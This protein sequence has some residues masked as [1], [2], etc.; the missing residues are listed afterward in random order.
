MVI[1]SKAGLVRVRRG[2]VDAPP[3]HFEKAQTAHNIPRAHLS[4][5][6]VAQPTVIG[7]GAIEA[8]SNLI[9]VFLSKPRLA[10]IVE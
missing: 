5:V 6:F 3:L 1:C 7:G 10:G 2:F 4:L 9:H 8:R